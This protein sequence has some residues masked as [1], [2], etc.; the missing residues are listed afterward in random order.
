MR[1][2][3]RFVLIAEVIIPSI[4]FLS[5]CAQEV[6]RKTEHFIVSCYN[7][8]DTADKVASIAEECYSRITSELGLP[9]RS[10][11][12]RWDKRIKIRIYKNFDDFKK[13]TNAPEWAGGRSSMREREIATWLGAGDFENSVLPHEM[14]HLILRDYFGAEK[15]IPLWLA[16]GIAQWVEPS[17]RAEAKKGILEGD[18]EKLFPLKDFWKKHDSCFSGNE[19]ILF[20][21]Q[22][23]SIVAFLMDYGGAYAFGILCR[24]LKDGKNVEDALR[25][26]YPQIARTI[27]VLEQQWLEHEKTNF[28]QEMIKEG[29]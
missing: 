3:V 18:P 20:Y 9:K 15:K 7:G 2:T 1:I 6:E 8:V 26:A 27:A 10:G 16:E 22:S 4:L 5:L 17:K 28:H 11:F 14:A 29:R 24:K 12:W 21:R 13:A 25:F 23:L 19:A